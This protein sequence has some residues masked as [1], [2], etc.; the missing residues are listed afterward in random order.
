MYAN[1]AVLAPVH[2][3][4]LTEWA[5][6]HLVDN[7]KDRAQMRDEQISVLPQDYVRGFEQMCGSGM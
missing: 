6:L 4:V 3:F 5:W 2:Y 7:L 1:E